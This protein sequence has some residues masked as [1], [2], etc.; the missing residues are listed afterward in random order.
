M[1]GF[2]GVQ[3][4]LVFKLII[5]NVIIFALQIFTREYQIEITYY[6]GLVPIYVIKKGFLWQFFTYMFLHDPNGFLHI[7]VNM[8]ALL[9]FG[10]P[11]E[12]TW[13]SKK[14]MIYYFF[15]GIGAGFTIFLLN[16]VMGG[17]GYIYPT[18]GASGAVFGLLL[19]FGVLFP[20]AQI[21][22]F[23]VIPIRAK[24]L[25]ILYGGF[26]LYSLISAGGQSNISHIGH[27][28]GLLFGIIYFLIFN[29]RTI[30]FKTKSF[31]A[32]FTEEISR[33][34]TQPKEEKGDNR[35]FLQGI[36]K[37]IKDSGSESLNDDEF[38]NLGYLKI[39]YDDDD[40]LCVEEDFVDSDEYCNN[41]SNYEA[42]ML[43]RI[44]KNL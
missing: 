22:L 44:N 7:F 23:F 34:K 11:I 1:N 24:Y 26:E 43:R 15:T 39:M 19:A 20:N 38:Q 16:V 32:K 6:L 36:L 2:G 14:F 21:L 8:Y 13:G 18:I 42:C 41:C 10:I 31:Q 35:A 25:V 5:A 29:K 30:T 3:K 4:S 27:L 37:K 17:T 28:G 40:D 33:R 12:Q 9:I